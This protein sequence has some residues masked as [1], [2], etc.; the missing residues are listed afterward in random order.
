MGTIIDE[1]S[2]A[3]P[4]IP[5]DSIDLNIENIELPTCLIV[6]MVTTKKSKK[7]K[8]KKKGK[9]KGVEV[10]EVEHSVENLAPNLTS[11]S[12]EDLDDKKNIVK[13]IFEQQEITQVVD[14]NYYA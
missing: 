8:K 2:V 6:D 10:A 12:V 14:A 13:G 1:D 3:I 4:G 11:G 9:K 5:D 7:K